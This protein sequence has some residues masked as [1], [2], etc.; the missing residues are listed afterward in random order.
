M[1]LGGTLCAE[2]DC[3]R[4]LGPGWRLCTHPWGSF[5]GVG[6][7]FFGGPTRRCCVAESGLRRR[8]W[9]PP[10]RC[11]RGAAGARRG[12]DKGA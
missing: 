11:W 9:Q 6:E 4:V 2:P 5:P 12:A 1:A 7:R 10:R 3:R 8:G